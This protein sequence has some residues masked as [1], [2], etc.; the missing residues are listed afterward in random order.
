[1]NQIRGLENKHEYGAQQVARDTRPL[2]IRIAEF[3]SKPETVLVIS[4]TMGSVIFLYPIVTDI[5]TLL[6][7]G[8]FLFVLTRKATLPCR[9]P[10]TSGLPDYND[11]NPG[12]GKP[13]KAGGISFFANDRFSK[14]EIWFTNDDL[15]THVLIFG[16]T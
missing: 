10:E 15:R 3:L 1:M 2:G 6:L 4:G 9:L 16:S 14:E 12:T 5:F 8:L 11:L 7:G 13:K